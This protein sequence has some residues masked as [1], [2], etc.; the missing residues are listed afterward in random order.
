M[1]A[2]TDTPPRLTKQVRCPLDLAEMMQAIAMHGDDSATGLDLL[3]EHLRPVVEARFKE[4]PQ[5]FQDW[6]RNR[7]AKAAAAEDA[8]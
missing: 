2:K 1:A 4:L 6:A 3:D 7:I 5:A 8:K